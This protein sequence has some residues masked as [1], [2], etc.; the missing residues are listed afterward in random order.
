MADAGTAEHH[1]HE[2]NALSYGT[3]GTATYNKIG[4]E[5]TFLR[6]L[7]KKSNDKAG[8]NR[9]IS[10]HFELLDERTTAFS[11]EAQNWSSFPHSRLTAGSVLHKL[12]LKHVPDASVVSVELPLS[13][14]TSHAQH[15]LEPPEYTS[16]SSVLAVGNARAPFRIGVNSSAAVA[17][18]VAFPSGS[19]NGALQLL[20]LEAHQIAIRR[21]ASMKEVCMLP[22]IGARTA[23]SW[24]ESADRILQVSSTNQSSSAKFLVV[25]PSGTTILHPRLTEGDTSETPTGGGDISHMAPPEIFIDSD[26]VVTI[27]HTRTGGHPHTYAAFNPQDHNLFGIVDISGTWSV[28]RLSGTKSVST[29]I[30]YQAR[31]QGSNCLTAAINQ[32]QDSMSTPD[33][34]GWHRICWIA[35]PDSPTSKLFVCNQRS[36][37]IFDH[38]GMILGQVGMRLGPTSDRNIILDVKT[39][40]RRRNHLYVLTT[41]RL[42]L[43]GPIGTGWKKSK[44]SE[45]LELICSWSHFRDRRDLGLCMAI[46]ESLQGMCLQS[47]QVQG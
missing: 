11:N 25:K 22:Y 14:Y 10:F 19:R 7:Q 4:K 33:M 16:S 2:T 1:V 3:L 35:E 23:G 9:E 45:P 31:L 27:P 41:S 34:K 15:G 46:L 47:W 28:W 37:A 40:N 44:Q 29:R 13:S 8:P 20:G 24:C 26:P 5:W 39:S 18:I 36:A 12:F 21:D 30:F 17:P 42:L 6:Q 38:K 43:F 32:S